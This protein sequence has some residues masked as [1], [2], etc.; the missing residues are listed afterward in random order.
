MRDVPT[1]LAVYVRERLAVLA[2]EWDA[3]Y[4]ENPVES[5]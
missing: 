1:E 2:A 5:E 4:P 3:M